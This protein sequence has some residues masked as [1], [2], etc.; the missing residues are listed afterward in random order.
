MG[1]RRFYRS[2]GATVMRTSNERENITT[3]CTFPTM[4]NNLP[5]ITL[6]TSKL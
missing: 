1:Q 5:W 6:I 4:S 2:D 3:Y